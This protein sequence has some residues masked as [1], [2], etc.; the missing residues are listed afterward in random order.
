MCLTVR[1]LN[2]GGGSRG[3]GS[4]CDGTWDEKGMVEYMYIFIDTSS[5]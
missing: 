2:P 3:I 5:S 4:V 1:E